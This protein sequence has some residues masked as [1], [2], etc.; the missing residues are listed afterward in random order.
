MLCR[1]FARSS[2][3]KPNLNFVR[4]KTSSL[5]TTAKPSIDLRS[6]G[7]VFG[8]GSDFTARMQTSRYFFSSTDGGDDKDMDSV[9]PPDSFYDEDAEKEKEF[10][11]I[12]SAVAHQKGLDGLVTN[13]NTISL[14][15]LDDTGALL[16]SNESLRSARIERENEPI[17]YE[18][19]MDMDEKW[20]LTPQEEK[21]VQVM[22][23]VA[24]EHMADGGGI[25][26]YSPLQPII[27]KEMFNSAIPWRKTEDYPR[28]DLK[29]FVKPTSKEMYGYD[30]EGERRCSG[31][32]QRRGVNGVLNCHVIDLDQ[33]SEFDILN[34]RRFLTQDGEILSRRESRLCAKCQRKV[35]KTIKR[36]R[37]MGILGHIDEF[38][39][40]DSK[41]LDR[42]ISYHE[43]VTKGEKNV[44]SK[45]IL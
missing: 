6:S 15:D 34:L 43:N 12:V 29:N 27:P 2:K 37:H 8:Q 7:R 10:L 17:R 30:R 41:P 20:A 36:A 39:L 42:G 45:T 32:K 5:F 1:L 26:D 28:P 40:K 16:D 33:L 25:A 23:E 44:L 11:D 13:K 38:V 22:E 18:D 14:E 19:E 24:F 35:A 31:K 4:C 21:Q 9:D 3:S